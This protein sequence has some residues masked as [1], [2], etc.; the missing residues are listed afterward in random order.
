MPS[1]DLMNFR[2]YVETGTWNPSDDLYKRAGS[3][4]SGKIMGLQRLYL[5]QTV[6]KNMMYRPALKALVDVG[7]HAPDVI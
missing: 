7:K 2:G 4:Q 5:A 3:V 1:K 6:K